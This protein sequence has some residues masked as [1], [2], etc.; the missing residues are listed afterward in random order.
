MIWL[1]SKQLERKI[2]E[3][4][5]SEKDT[6]HYMLATMIY[7]FLY[8]LLIPIKN[9]DDYVLINFCTSILITL[10][11]LSQTFKINQ[12]KDDKDFVKRFVAITWVVTVKIFIA[13]IGFGVFIVLFMDLESPSTA[14]GIM[15]CAFSIITHVLFYILT[16]NS[17][18]RLNPS[19]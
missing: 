4:K 17:F 14:I 1:D 16:V 9:Y 15:S 5:L 13:Y 7:G 19:A 11:G 12:K 10:I 2:S 6:F 18:K 8:T 3:N